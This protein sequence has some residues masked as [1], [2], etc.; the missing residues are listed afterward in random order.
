[1]V[2]G[3]SVARASSRR[4]LPPAG[5]QGYFQPLPKAFTDGRVTVD[6]VKAL[7]RRIA[8]QMWQL[9]NPLPHRRTCT[10]H[11]QLAAAKRQRTAWMP[12]PHHCSVASQTNPGRAQQPADD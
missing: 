10:L 7:V 8:L 9:Q 6:D 5:A 4:S 2:C 11:A 12:P 3:L 1:M